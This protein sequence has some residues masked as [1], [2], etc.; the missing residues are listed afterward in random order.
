[1]LGFIQAS[2]E[3]VETQKAHGLDFGANV[4]F[5][6]T[7]VLTLKS[8]FDASFLINFKQ[9]DGDG[10]ELRYAGTLSPCDVTSCS[11]MP[12]WRSTWQNSLVFGPA[13]VSLTTNYTQGY[14]TASVDYGG[15]R[16]NCDANAADAISTATYADGSPV[17]CSQGSAVTFDL[18]G[19]YKV[20]E[21]VT[22][23][24]DIM[25][26]LDQGAD[27]DPSAAYALFGYNPAW[28]G[29][30]IIGRYFRF[31]VKYDF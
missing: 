21:K 22:L 7:D 18:T 4:T 30:N 14:S 10:N 25:N 24:G 1:L 17:N 8:S 5:P 23:Y 12:K 27:F 6:V 28:Q 11:G 15:E 26:V 20:N 13:T 19:R 31:G 9:I 29:S 3:N 16:W 2:F